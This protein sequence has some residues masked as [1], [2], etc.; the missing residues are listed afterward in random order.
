MGTSA[1]QTPFNRM[2]VEGHKMTSPSPEYRLIPLTQGQFAKV[3]SHR[4]DELTRWKWH[5]LWSKG[6]QSFYARRTATVNGKRVA[7]P[8][9]RYILGLER[10]DRREGEHG[11]R[12][13]LNNTDENLR[14]STAGQNQHNQKRPRHNTSGL[15]GVSWHRRI[16]KWQAQIRVAGRQMSLG[17]Y[18]TVEAAHEAYFQSAELHFGEFARRA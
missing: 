13:T 1:L 15:K 16:G 17:Y 3:S 7:I 9:H 10:G 18:A 5:A 12:D 11:D 2:A 14:I 6:M 8:M 4:Y